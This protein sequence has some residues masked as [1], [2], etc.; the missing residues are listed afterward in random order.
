MKILYITALCIVLVAFLITG[1][2]F[3]VPLKREVLLQTVETPKY[4]ET[5][6]NHTIPVLLNY[7]EREATVN[8]VGI[9]E[10]TTT[11]EVVEIIVTTR[12][13]TGRMLLDVED[14]AFGVDLQEH[15]VYVKACAENYITESLDF[16]DITIGIDSS[17]ESIRG[18]SGN[19]AM[20][21]GIVSIFRNMTIDSRVAVSA[22]V[23]SNGRLLEVV[24][25][26]AKIQVA[27]N[28]G[29]DAIIL[30]AEQE[31]DIVNISADILIIQPQD[32]GEA[33]PHILIPRAGIA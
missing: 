27:A 25:P 31:F 21:I 28:E 19:A 33:L 4:I 14:T 16:Y 8:G 3:D 24:S 6:I 22:G 32:V 17:A 2:F 13:G 29:M 30:P 23:S 7:S 15:L 5:Q 18:S 10:N 20:C 11:G 26:E 1:A 12:P 9:F